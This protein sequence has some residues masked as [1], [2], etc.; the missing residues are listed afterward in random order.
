MSRDVLGLRRRP[1][2]LTPSADALI[3]GYGGAEVLDAVQANI[4][5]ADMGLNLVYANSK[6]QQT[7]RAVG[8]ELERVFNV[9]VADILGGSIHRFHK[10]PAR[11]E[12]ILAD[13]GF[14]PRDA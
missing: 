11:I 3:A 12:R 2:Q 10:D 9:R 14:Q 6:A 5:I 4:F 7:L 1:Q 8:P 13:P